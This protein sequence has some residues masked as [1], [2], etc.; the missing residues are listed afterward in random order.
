MTLLSI[1]LWG[2]AGAALA[3]VS[4]KTQT[5]SV[6]RIAPSR[7]TSSMVL[8]IGGAIIRWLVTGAVLVLAL[9]NSIGA[10][11][12]VFIMFIICRTLFIFLWQDALIQKPLQ[13]NHVKD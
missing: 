1:M 10:M 9:S 5:W 2:L 13:T 6:M 11:L 3:F 7:P 12:S 4:L 8:V